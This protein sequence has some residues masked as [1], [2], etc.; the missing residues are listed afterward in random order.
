MFDFIEHVDPNLPLSSARIV[1]FRFSLVADLMIL[2]NAVNL[3]IDKKN[4]Q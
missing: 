4:W 1:S 2:G 3:L